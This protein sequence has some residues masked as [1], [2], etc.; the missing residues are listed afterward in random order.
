LGVTADD[1]GATDAVIL[2]FKG[3]NC[4]DGGDQGC[5]GAW[6]AHRLAPSHPLTAARL[7]LEK[8]V[9]LTPLIGGARS[10]LAIISRYAAATI[11]RAPPAPAL[12][13]I[14][15]CCRAAAFHWSGGHRGARAN[16]FQCTI[17]WPPCTLY[18]QNNLVKSMSK[19]DDVE[20]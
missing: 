2:Y 11:T 18:S 12:I 16:V 5:N 9:T 7:Y 8:N 17:E 19:D 3:Q 14:P 20:I 10:F 6:H 15:P 4:S 1:I 13:F